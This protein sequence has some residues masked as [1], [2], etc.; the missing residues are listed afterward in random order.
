MMLET[1]CCGGLSHIHTSTP[2]LSFQWHNHSL[3]VAALILPYPFICDV[4]CILDCRW[5]NLE[6]FGFH[7]SVC[8]MDFNPSTNFLYTG[9]D[10]GTIVVWDLTHLMETWRLDPHQRDV[11]PPIRADGS[12]S[13]RKSWKK[14][15]KPWAIDAANVS[16]EIPIMYT[17][18]AHSD[19]FS[20]L[21]LISEPPSLITAGY[22]CRVRL[23]SLDG[24]SLGGLRQK[25]S[26]EREE[27][28][29]YLFQVDEE[30][31]VSAQ[32][33]RAQSV[34]SIIRKKRRVLNAFQAVSTL[35]DRA[36]TFMTEQKN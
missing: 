29:P 24:Q 26:D 36:S 34:L 2:H 33:S 14:R 20:S 11:Y 4:C 17:I 21:H 16:V 10:H 5:N 15:V 32:M 9:D 7:P 30:R 28:D 12:D 13:S 35:G 19:S 6:V 3:N 1:V 25:I 18:D 8:A 22:D 31:K 27:N 23:W